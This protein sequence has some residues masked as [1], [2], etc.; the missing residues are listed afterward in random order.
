MPSISFSGNLVVQLTDD[1]K[2]TSVPLNF[3]TQ[4][5][6]KSMYDF[7]YGVVTNQALPQGSITNPRIIMV[8]ILSGSAS[9]SWSG[10]GTAPTVMTANSTPPPSDPAM[11]LFYTYAAGANT[12]YITTAAPCTGRVWFFE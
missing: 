10:S 9:L 4:Y 3:T 2:P 7:S 1:A 5:T 11:Q 8:Q 6:E 12:L